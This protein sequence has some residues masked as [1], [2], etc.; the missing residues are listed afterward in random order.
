MEAG[1]L[2]LEGLLGPGRHLTGKPQMGPCLARESRGCGSCPPCTLPSAGGLQLWGVPNFTDGQADR[3]LGELKLW[4][5][6]RERESVCVWCVRVWKN[7]AKYQPKGY[8]HG[9][10]PL[11][12]SSPH[13][14]ALWLWQ[15]Q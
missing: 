4:E 9:P 7:C 14:P 15:R 1:S 13:Q 6:S 3:E 10:W 12:A 11:L 2:L 8:A 5:G